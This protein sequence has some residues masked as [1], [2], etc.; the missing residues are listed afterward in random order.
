MLKYALIALLTLPAFAQTTVIG[1]SPSSGSNSGGGGSTNA[2]SVIIARSDLTGQTGN[3]SPTAF[4]TI[5]ASAGGHYRIRCYV[6]E[7]TAAST[8]STLPTCAFSYTDQ[9]TQIAQ[10]GTY[11]TQSGIGNAV[12][13]NSVSAGLVQPG[14]A[15]F[16]AKA[17]TSVSVSTSNYASSGTTAMQ[18]ALHVTLEYLGQ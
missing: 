15:E 13:Y 8:A 12:G 3:V 1:A 17:Q 5:P 10:S 7:T 9:D 6:V 4:Y 11:L 16:V 14:E 18:Y 2:A